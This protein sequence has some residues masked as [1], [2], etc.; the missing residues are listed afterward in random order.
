MQ[1]FF[2]VCALCVLVLPLSALYFTGSAL[3]GTLG[4]AVQTLRLGR[5][6]QCLMLGAGPQLAMATDGRKAIHQLL[7]GTALSKRR[8]GAKYHRADLPGHTIHIRT[9]TC[10]VNPVGQPV[11]V[12]L[13]RE[14]RGQCQYAACTWM[15]LSLP[16]Q[17]PSGLQLHVQWMPDDNVLGSE[18]LAAGLLGH[19]LQFLLR[20]G[21]QFIISEGGIGIDSPFGA[22]EGRIPAML[23]A[24]AQCADR[25]TAATSNG[26]VDVGQLLV[27]TAS[28]DPSGLPGPRAK[29]VDHLLSNPR[30]HPQ[31]NQVRDQALNDPAPEVRFAAARHS[32]PQGHSVIE[33]IVFHPDAR[34]GLRQH[35][36][37]YLIRNLPDDTRLSL[38]ETLLEHGPERLRQI[39]V[40]QVAQR[41]HR[42]A[43]PLLIA[44]AGT[45]DLQ[46]RV[47]VA[48]ALGQLEAPEGEAVLLQFLNCH[49]LPLRVCAAEALG[50][51]GTL[52]AI[53]PL[54]QTAEASPPN[55]LRIAALS[56]VHSIQSRS[57]PTATGALSLAETPK[58]GGVSLPIS[59][60]PQTP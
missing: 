18:A 47:D 46:T 38:L 31:S 12:P 36:L 21:D 51:A 7:D 40:R 22:I 15:L 11:S 37:R 55:E 8:L 19:E 43:L 5:Q 44:A 13:S 17:L 54:R 49:E 28:A 6:S 59:D 3:L 9:Q 58:L 52:T 35:A 16:E 29:A 26:R 25:L 14:Q 41:Q 56:A 30:R 33:A 27:E 1:I 24:L 34:D 60:A 23:T 42:A 20:T 45:Q 10:A 4:W 50:R 48:E 32:G 2:I 39:A 57:R 53:Q